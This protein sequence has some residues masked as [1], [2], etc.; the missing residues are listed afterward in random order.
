[1]NDFLILSNNSKYFISGC[2]TNTNNTYYVT[3][4]D[5]D[6]NSIFNSVG[7]TAATIKIYASKSRN[8]ELLSKE[9][10]E[11]YKRLDNIKEL[12][13]DWDGYGAE[14][15]SKTL[16][17]KCKKIIRSLPIQPSIYPTGRNS[18]QLQ[19]ELDDK[20]YL[21]FEIFE[22]KIACLEVPKRNYIEAKEWTLSNTEN[23]QI[24]R[25]VDD[26]YG[27]QSTEG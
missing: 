14:S 4:Y 10:L 3:L 20:S 17:E 13:V 9:V 25:I 6:F 2:S 24:K 27:R 12:G 26:F 23:A 1:M 22:D 16:I 11:S 19:Y 8:S 5:I 7:N 21:E 15:F 18:I